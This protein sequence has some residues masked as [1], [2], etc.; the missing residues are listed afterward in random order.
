MSIS[1]KNIVNNLSSKFF[2]HFLFLISNIINEQ[3][4]IFK[5]NEYSKFNISI[6]KDKNQCLK[7]PITLYIQLSIK[8]H[9]IETTFQHFYHTNRHN[10]YATRSLKKFLSLFLSFSREEESRQFHRLIREKPVPR[11]QTGA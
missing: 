6:Y 8:F 7:F 9:S 10:S 3:S 1:I 5:L 4:S 2:Y 11:V